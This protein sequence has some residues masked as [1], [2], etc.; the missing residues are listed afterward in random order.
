M[1]T[2]LLERKVFWKAFRFFSKH[3]LEEFNFNRLVKETGLSIMSTHDVARRMTKEGFLN[4]RRL[5]NL[6]L[7]SLNSDEPFVRQLRVLEAIAAVKSFVKRIKPLCSKIVL[8]GSCAVGVQTPDSDIDL[9]AIS[10]EKSKLATIV[11]ESTPIN[12][13]RPI[14]VIIENSASALNM[15]NGSKVLWENIQKGIVLYET[16]ND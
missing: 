16:Y 12:M 2:A 14:N 15:R 7:F 3:P 4:I 1:E 9:F 8:F 11:E 6:K 13:K 5:G 10:E